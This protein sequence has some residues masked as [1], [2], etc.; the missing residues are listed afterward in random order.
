M[1]PA[2]KAGDDHCHASLHAWHYGGRVDDP[3]ASTMKKTLR[4][5]TVAGATQ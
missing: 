3:P 5:P 2:L 1:E 4:K